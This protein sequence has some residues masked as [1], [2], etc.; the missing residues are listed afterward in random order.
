[1]EQKPVFCL[2][3]I[4]ADLIL[5]FGAAKQA[6]RGE[7]VPLS[8]TDVEFR[9]GGSVANTAAGLARLGVPVVFCGTCGDDAYGHALKNEL[10]RLGCD[11]S[12]MCM[13]ATVPT[14]LIAIVVDENGERTAF[15]THRTHASQHQILP[16][17][18]PDRLCERIGWLHCGG[19][20]L[21][22]EPAA[23]VQLEVMRRCHEANIP[24]SLDIMARMESRGDPVYLQNLKAA[25]ACSDFILGSIEDEIPLLS[26]GSDD[27]SI[28]S[29]CRGGKVIVARNGSRGATVYTASESFPCPAF[30]VP[31]VDT[32]GAGDAY[33]AGFV[34]SLLGGLSLSEAN[35]TANAVAAC[36]VMHTG[37]RACPTQAELATFL[38]EHTVS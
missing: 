38:S 8:A 23:S 5:P 1:M 27:D 34:A 30:M 36:C 28:R 21:R 31:V 32:I 35:R 29:L 25:A 3:D 22:E 2:G 13:D 20:L 19:V 24:V 6:A 11:V 16:S 7:A 14:L 10:A 12:P 4:C 17:Q 15:A 33:N 18:I 26:G 37:G 9:H